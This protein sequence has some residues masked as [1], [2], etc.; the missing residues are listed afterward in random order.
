[1]TYKV[2]NDLLKD[3]TGVEEL[4]KKLSN[5]DWIRLKRIKEIWV[6]FG[7]KNEAHDYLETWCE[8]Q[9]WIERNEKLNNLGI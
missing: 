7:N 8:N 4:R 5:G 9:D 2:L 6:S 3:E 1:M